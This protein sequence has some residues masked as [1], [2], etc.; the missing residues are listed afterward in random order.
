MNITCSCATCYFCILFFV[1]ICLWLFVL[2]EILCDRKMC[3]YVG[4]QLG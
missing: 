1:L 2:Q 3:T 4:G